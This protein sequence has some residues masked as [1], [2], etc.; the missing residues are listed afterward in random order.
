MK[1]SVGSENGG[2]REPEFDRHAES[3]LESHARNV[4]L[5]G[6]EP[7][8]FA[9]YKVREVARLLGGEAVPRI[10]DFGA[11]IG[12]SVPYFEKYFPASSLTCLDVSGASLDHARARYGDRPRYL[13]YDG[14]TIPAEADSFDLAFTACVFHHIDE[15]IHGR[16]LAEI[17]RVLRPGGH[18]FLFEHNPLNPLT[19]H[20]VNTCPFDENAVLVASGRMRRRFAEASFRQIR[21]EFC[22]FFPGLLAALR[23]LERHLGWLPLGAQYLIWGR[24]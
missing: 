1:P 23:P 20:A 10:L 14:W 4:A 5:T 15:A 8:Y 11:G 2:Y 7:A 21:R 6:E 22:L 16:L 12:A 19:R 17:R 18:F 24:K 13:P 3:Y 9:E